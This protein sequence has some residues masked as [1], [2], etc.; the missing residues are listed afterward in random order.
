MHGSAYSTRKKFHRNL[1]FIILLMENLNPVI[2]FLEI[3]Q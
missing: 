2:I 3:S 1:N